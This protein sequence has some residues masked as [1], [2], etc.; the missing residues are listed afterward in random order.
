MNLQ[1]SS[2]D[3]AV[4]GKGLKSEVLYVSKLDWAKIISTAKEEKSGRGEIALVVLRGHAGGEGLVAPPG[5]ESPLGIKIGPV[6]RV[7]RQ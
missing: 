1:A 7:I 3:L 2:H 4:G 6:P 5:K